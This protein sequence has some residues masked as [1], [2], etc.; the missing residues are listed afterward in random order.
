[1][2]SVYGNVSAITDI[3]DDYM[4]TLEKCKMITKED[5]DKYNPIFKLIGKLLWTIAPL[6]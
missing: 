2:C 4:K 3:Y 6:M 5:C 1:M